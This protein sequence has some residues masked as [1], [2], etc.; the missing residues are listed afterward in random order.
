MSVLQWVGIGV[1][2][3]ITAVGLFSIVVENDQPLL[4]KIAVALLY[5][6]A[7]W[8]LWRMDTPTAGIIIFAMAVVGSLLMGMRD[9]MCLREERH[10]QESEALRK[11]LELLLAW[12]HLVA[13]PQLDPEYLETVRELEHHD[14]EDLAAGVVRTIKEIIEAVDKSRAPSTVISATGR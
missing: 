6:L 10:R 13:S 11:R 14:G 5:V 12:V 1:V 2:A 9:V 3:V 8:L 7:C 4:I